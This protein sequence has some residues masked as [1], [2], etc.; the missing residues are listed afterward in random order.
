[1]NNFI[2]IFNIILV[3]FLSACGF[4]EKLLASPDEYTVPEGSLVAECTK[5]DDTFKFV[6]Q[7]DGVYL[8]YINDIEQSQD[9]VDN[10]I[11]QAYLHG[12]SVENYLADEFPGTCTFSDYISDDE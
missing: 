2:I 11:E 12:S 5:N 3:V 1:M 9:E 6:Y 4:R 8:Y 7:A 10:M